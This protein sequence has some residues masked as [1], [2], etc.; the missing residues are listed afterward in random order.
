MTLSIR[1]AVEA[2]VPLILR[3]IRSLAEYEKMADQVVATESGIRDA[4]FGTRRYGE[5]ILGQVGAEA[6]GFALF[7]HNFSTFRG[8]PGI[9]LEDLFVEPQWRGH[10]FGRQLLAHIA[11]VA[12]ARGCHRMEWSVLDWNESAIDFYRRAGARP[13]ADWTMFR[14]TG[15]ALRALAAG[16]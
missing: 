8:A 2:D 11:A 6:V 1:P 5:V 10:G 3:M 13:L 4:L 9:F 12:V 16:G 14:L 15:D 7:F